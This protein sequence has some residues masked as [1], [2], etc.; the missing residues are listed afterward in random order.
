MI[1]L[2][3]ITRHNYW[4]FNSCLRELP[5]IGCHYIAHA[6]AINQTICHNLKH[7]FMHFTLFNLL[8]LG[9]GYVYALLKFSLRTIQNDHVWDWNLSYQ[10]QRLIIKTT[11]WP[12]AKFKSAIRFGDGHQLYKYFWSP[13]CHNIPSSYYS[14]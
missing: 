5:G 2:S 10:K 6:L 14:N 8:H 13:K 7:C 11:C 3:K 1:F 12:F 4:L 9:G